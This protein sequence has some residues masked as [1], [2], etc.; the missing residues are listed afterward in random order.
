MFWPQVALR[1]KTQLL[2]EIAHQVCECVPSS[3]TCFLE[4]H[5]EVRTEADMAGQTM[6]SVLAPLKK[7]VETLGDYSSVV[8]ANC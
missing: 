2:G 5:P 8:V 1:G 3:H 7:S 6:M 4:N